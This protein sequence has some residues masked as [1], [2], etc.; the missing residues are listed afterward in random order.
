LIADVGLA[1]LLAVPLCRRGSESMI[2]N[3]QNAR[4]RTRRCDA[5]AH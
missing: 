1:D 4:Y 5:A 3:R 2:I